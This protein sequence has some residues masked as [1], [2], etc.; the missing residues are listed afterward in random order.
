[1]G[2]SL[3]DFAGRFAIATLA[4]PGEYVLLAAKQMKTSDERITIDQ[5]ERP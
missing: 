5:P 1:M 3:T 2:T 4:E